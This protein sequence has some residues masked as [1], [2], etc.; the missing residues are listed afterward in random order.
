MTECANGGF[1]NRFAHTAAAGT[2]NDQLLPIR[3]IQLTGSFENL[4]QREVES[5]LQDYILRLA[6]PRGLGAIYPV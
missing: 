6:L 5:T 3:S 2:G 1:K 4:D